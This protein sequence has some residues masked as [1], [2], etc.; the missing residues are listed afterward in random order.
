MIAPALVALALG[1]A[2]PCAPVDTS[3]TPDPTT[4]AEY[5]RVGDA[6][7]RAGSRLTAKLAYRSAVALDPADE[8]S[9][10][11]LAALCSDAGAAED[12]FR[13]GLARMDAG[14][15]RGAIDR[16][17]EARRT[18]EDPAAALLEG[19]CH[20]EL[21]EEA[22]AAPLL[23]VAEG[24][25]EH[26]D[27]ARFYLG[28][29]ALRGGAFGEAASLFDAAAANPALGPV[30]SGLARS[31][32]GDGRL[33]FSFVA[34]SGWDSNV[35]LAPASGASVRPASDTAYA[36]TASALFRPSGTVGPYL[37]ASGTLHDQTT[38]NAYDVSGLDGAAGWQWTRPGRSLL[39]EYD[40]AFRTLAGAR[41][42]SAH[43]LLTSGFLQAG[44]TTLAA[45]YLL[46]FEDYPAAAYDA[47]SGIF[48]RIEA[49]ASWQLTPQLRASAGYGA[50]MDSAKASVLS[51]LEHGPRA[52]VRLA[53]TRTLRFGLDLAATFRRYAELDATLTVRRLDR[54]LDGVAFGEVD[55]AP[56]WT[57]RV[58]V[59]AR[60]ALSNVDALEYQRF[61]PTVG[62]AYVMG[63]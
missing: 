49:R 46:R 11:A 37:R 17:R 42:L 5:R 8:A 36:L 12:P 41:F 62:L 63:M 18:A 45:T 58:S 7:R 54:Y 38:Q 6:E 4:A 56:R 13:A 43:R 55:L 24:F 52:E 22:E 59:Q 14:D 26:R 61:V 25:P 53:A 57:A 20:Y 21:G 16:F 51:F 1:A 33:V 40:Y 27:M 15:L 19:I 9:R 34:E 28:L 35:T 30:A 31:A 29:V 44:A 50:G 32:R 48:Q 2:D 47:Y 39:T 23:R 60:K 10:A 3:S